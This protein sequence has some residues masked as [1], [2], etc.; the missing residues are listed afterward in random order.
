MLPSFRLLERAT[1]TS[2][3]VD[4]ARG[5][6]FADLDD[7]GQ[8]SAGERVAGAAAQ[9]VSAAAASVTELFEYP[10]PGNTTPDGAYEVRGPLTRKECATLRQGGAVD[11]ERPALKL[12]L[13]YFDQDL[14]GKM[15]VS[16]NIRGWKQL[17]FPPAKATV[18]AV[19]SALVFGKPLQGF[20]VDVDR[21][22]A[23]RYANSTG[24]YDKQGRI[25]QARLGEFLAEF[26]KVGG[27]MGFE[28]VVELLSS[29][30]ATGKVSSG[31]FRSLFAVCEM[32]NKGEKVVTT[33]Q[34][35]G[36]FDGS[37]LWTAAAMTNEE[38]KRR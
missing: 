33:A 30:N 12:H 25:A 38:G 29:K 32:L 28:Q 19:V 6:V 35:K 3:V 22:G 13:D 16:E 4:T 10:V 20:A 8:I 17:G 36:L 2:Y 14:D 11:A 27:R 24:I 9:R 5:E 34:F 7:D 15:T 23:K 37:L 26:D 1:Q 18:K 21:I 31:Q